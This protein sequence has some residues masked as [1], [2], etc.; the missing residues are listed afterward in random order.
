MRTS[1]RL[2]P[3][4][5]AAVL[6]LAV[7]CGGGDDGDGAADDA[8]D[9]AEEVVPDTG[10]AAV[11]DG[12]D[13]GDAVDACTLLEEAEVAPHVLATGPGSGSDGVCTWENPDTFESVTLTVGEPGT[14]VDDLPEPSPYPDA[15][16]VDGVGA[17]ARYSASNGIV[18]FV[19]GDRACE[20]QL[21]S[22]TLDD[23]AQRAGAIELADLAL[24]RI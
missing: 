11:D 18:E 19:A 3:A 21:A 23:A 4:I 16:P 24:G 5:A 7:G 17:D 10:A 15:E 6:L 22:V 8:R 12:A 1:R 14:A 2:G 13:A 9:A 20:L